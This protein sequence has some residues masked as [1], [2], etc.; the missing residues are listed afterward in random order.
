MLNRQKKDNN[1]KKAPRAGFRRRINPYYEGMTRGQIA[2]DTAKTAFR[3]FTVTVL[4]FVYWF[5]ML[6]LAS[7]FLLNVWKTTIEE[8]VI[9][10]LILG[11]VSSA[12]YAGVLVHRKFYY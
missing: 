8:I 4:L 11:A 7:L 1:G 12:I 3:W 2:A 6:L 9:Y 10:S 5:A